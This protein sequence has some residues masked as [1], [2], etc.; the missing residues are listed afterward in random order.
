[1][2]ENMSLA[3]SELAQALEICIL[4][5]QP[6][7]IMGMPG[8]GKSSIVE[9]VCEKIG[10]DLI[11]A[12]PVVDNP[13]DYKGFPVLVDVD[14]KKSKKYMQYM[15]HAK[16][17][18]EFLPFGG[19]RQLITADKL[20]VHFADDVGQAQTSVQC[21]Y[22]QL[23]LNRAVNEHKVSDN[24]VF[25]AATNRKQDKAGVKGIISMLLDRFTSVVELQ[26][27]LE[28]WVRWAIENNLRHEVVSW[29]RYRP[30]V[31]SEFKPTPD[32]SRTPTPRGIHAMSKMMDAGVPDY[33]QIRMFSGAIGKARA[34]EFVGFLR[35]YQNLPDPDKVI[36]DPDNG[37]IPDEPSHLYALCGAISQRAT[38]NN[39]ERIV[40]YADRLPDEFSVLLIKDC[41]SNDA[42]LTKSTAFNRWV[43]NHQDV[44]L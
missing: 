26:T 17:V 18:P 34:T 12:H 4:A 43:I 41:I 3:P 27:S 44:L 19:L 42:A 22:G 1:M 10:A 7:L 13:T 25:V 6:M 21:A 39:L 36:M 23:L 28:D 5:K 37:E 11:V 30:E 16:K 32:F 8:Q 29:V 40:K 15:S 14:G 9:Q 2:S 38:K 24:V 33:L 20:T 35:I 31:L